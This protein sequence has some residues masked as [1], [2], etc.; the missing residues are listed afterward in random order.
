[1]NPVFETL[2]SAMGEILLNEIQAGRY[3]G[4]KMS[5]VSPRTMQRWR[6]EGRGPAYVRVG[7]LIRYRQ[8][9]LSEW[10]DLQQ[11]CSTSER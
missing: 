2:P 4:G 10:L 3:L 8:S 9:A 5:P 1:M 11:R 7:R 6:M